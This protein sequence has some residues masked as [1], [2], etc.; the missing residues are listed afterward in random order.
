[1][2]VHEAVVESHRELVWLECFVLNPV[3]GVPQKGGDGVIYLNHGNTNR[4]LCFVSG[5][6]PSLRRLAASAL[7]KWLRSLLRLAVFEQLAGS[8]QG[9]RQ[10]GATE[11][12]AL[13]EWPKAN[14]N[15]GARFAGLGRIQ[16]EPD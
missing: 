16:T 9:C 3:V 5:A 7:A 8:Q 12:L 1:M 11:C 6:V 14:L 2:D 13:H 4:F 10:F 15:G